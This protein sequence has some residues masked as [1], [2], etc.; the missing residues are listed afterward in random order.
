MNPVTVNTITTSDEVSKRSDEEM[1]AEALRRVEGI[2]TKTGKAEAIGVSE[3]TIRRWLAGDIPL[4]LRKDTR[5]PLVRFLTTGEENGIHEVP[6]PDPAGTPAEQLLQY[7]GVRAGLRRVAKE[8]T[9]KDLIAVAYTIAT[10]DRWPV[11]EFKKL[12]AWRDA[13]LGQQSSE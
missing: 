7:L 5:D 10:K 3:G 1:V 2:P 4:P 9:D 8:L 12:D 11:E 6:T 13:I